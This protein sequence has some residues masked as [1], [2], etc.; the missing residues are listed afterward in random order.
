VADT[1]TIPHRFH[2]PPDSGNGG[3][4]AG[5]AARFVGDG[6]VEATLRAPPPLETPMTVERADG[7]V[8]VLDGE[9]LV[10]ESRR[11]DDRP[12]A[13]PP[14]ALDEAAGAGLDP[15][16]VLPDHIFPSCFTCGPLRE[17]GD[18]LRLLPG[19]VGVPDLVATT[20]VPHESMA[21]AAGAVDDEIVWAALD[22]PTYWVHRHRELPAV[23]GRLTVDIGGEA[24]A[25][26]QLVVVA[27]DDGQEGRKLL[28][29]SAL[30]RPDGELVAA[31]RAVWV[32]IDV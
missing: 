27:R 18:G 29:S 14:V 32:Q 13:P 30:Y 10:I 17:E 16:E 4:S 2:G 15:D 7:M 20:W 26:E 11:A 8:R 24:R 5:A 31:A 3:W 23:L 28:S 9:Q 22:C 12:D 6:P 1:L 25:G 21:D 19:P